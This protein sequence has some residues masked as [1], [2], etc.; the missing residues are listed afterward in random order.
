MVAQVIVVDGKVACRLAQ[1]LAPWL[2]GLCLERWGADAVL[3]SGGLGLL[4]FLALCALR[5]RG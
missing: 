4:V 2:F 3:V 5:A 1:A